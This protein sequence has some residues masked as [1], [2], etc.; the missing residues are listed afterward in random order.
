[1]PRVHCC[2][3]T[4]AL[5]TLPGCRCA[6]Q[7]IARY[8]T[9]VDYALLFNYRG[10]G[11][12]TGHTTR[13]GIVLDATAAVQFLRDD[14]SVPVSRIVL[15]RLLPTR[16]NLPRRLTSLS[17]QVGH[18][19]GGGVAAQVA[20][21]FPG[22][23]ICG[24]RTFS[25]IADVAPFFVMPRP[26]VQAA[27]DPGHDAATAP[28]ISPA[29]LR[30]NAALAAMAV[31]S[32]VVKHVIRWELDSAAAWGG[33]RGYKWIVHH[34]RDDIIP[35]HAQLQTGVAR[36]RSSG[37]PTSATCCARARADLSGCDPLTVQV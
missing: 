8:L 3:G 4:A 36:L 35:V 17:L 29:R 19:L 15:V 20:S 28:L 23:A 14:M 31:V 10:V 32:A 27:L 9:V 12:S 11:R 34:P 30:R 5:L 1:M 26:L 25:S 22:I 37:A 33:I 24:E 16:A 2:T 7:E 6:P 13:W 18:S 21:L